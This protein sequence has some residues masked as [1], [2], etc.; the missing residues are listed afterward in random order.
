MTKTIGIVGWKTGDNSFGITTG[1]AEYF[2][3]FGDIRIL[4]PVAPEDIDTH[5]DLLVLPGG[6]DIS[7]TVYA[8][9]PSFTL[10]R[11]CPY[12]EYFDQ[13]ILPEYI[14]L[15]TPI[16]G[17]C[18]GHQALGIYFGMF[19]SQDLAHPMN[20][21]DRSKLIHGI[22][23]TQ[24]GNSILGIT[25]TS[26]KHNEKRP[27]FEVN[28]LHHQGFETKH[29]SPSVLSQ[30]VVYGTSPD[31]IIETFGH[32]EKPIISV[33]WHPEDIYDKFSFAA[34]KKLLSFKK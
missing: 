8:Q 27:K 30:I 17:I 9:I 10:S 2:S 26:F 6:P 4:G 18:R 29:Q 31:N 19:L 24:A 12:K 28:S 15:D 34:I 1:Y 3:Q 11:P 14:K 22:N 25:N 5:L 23:F 21:S 33:Q 32:T 20:D 16:F 7:P 13:Y